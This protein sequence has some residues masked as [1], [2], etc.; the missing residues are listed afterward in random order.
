MRQQYLDFL[1]REPEQA[2]L[3]YWSGQLRACDADLN[4]LKLRKIEVS[5]AFFMSEEFQRSG[6]YLYRLYRAGLGRQPDYG[7]FKSDRQRVI[8]G[9][10]LEALRT[11]FAT[12]FVSRPAF[13]E[14][15][16]NAT[17]ADGFV[18][19][20]MQTVAQE[21]GVDLSSRRQ[22]L[23]A[24]YESGADLNHSRSAGL[25]AVAD[26]TEVKT[27]LN[28]QSFV[29]MEY[30]GYLQRDMDPDGLNFWVNVLNSEK[31][32]NYRGMVCSFLTSTEYQRRFSPVVTHSNAECR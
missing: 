32:G 31:Q 9:A 10:D 13:I 28:N 8:G 12:E 20:L 7:E 15:Y 2:G 4:C 30:F 16:Q 21:A 24:A 29:L 26:S 1:G 23:I 6:D 22:A 18:G 5:A 17:W 3:S 11:E 19:A 27:A 25:R 14:K